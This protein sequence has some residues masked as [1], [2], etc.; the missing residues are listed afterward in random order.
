MKHLVEKARNSKFTFSNQSRILL[1]NLP[2]DFPM[3]EFENYFWETH[4][5]VGSRHLIAFLDE[6]EKRKSETIKSL[7]PAKNV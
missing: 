2:D 3:E 1:E 5:I 6:R 7:T 4:C